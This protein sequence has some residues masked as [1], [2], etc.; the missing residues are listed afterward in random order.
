MTEF[1]NPV[2]I[3]VIVPVHNAS[4]WV[5]KCIN[6]L[7]NQ[8]YDAGSFEIILVDNN[9]SD[10]SKMRIRRHPRVRLLEETVQSAYA[11][12]NR[13]VRESQGDV[14]GFTDSDLSLIHI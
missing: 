11:A 10:D 13:G 6:G 12:R 1:S 14:L 2:R 7:L 4:A 3:S 8:D 5:E 9:S